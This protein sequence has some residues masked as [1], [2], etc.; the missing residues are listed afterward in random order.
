MMIYMGQGGEGKHI[1]L[2][3]RN[4]KI[5]TTLNIEQVMEGEH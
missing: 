3:W 2:W 5:M 4:I 1:E